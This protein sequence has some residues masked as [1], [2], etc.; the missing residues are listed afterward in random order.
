MTA[1]KKTAP[2]AAPKKPRRWRRRILL[3]GLLPLVA[4]MALFKW[5]IAPVLIRQAVMVAVAARI[6][7]RVEVRGASLGF[8]EVELKGVSLLDATGRVA[9]TADAVVIRLDRM[10]FG[11]GTPGI[12]SLRLV[13]PDVSMT[14]EAD[15]QIDLQRVLSP[16]PPA[17]PAQVL[18]APGGGPPAEPAPPPPPSPLL[19]GKISV[20]GGTLRLVTSV[21]SPT[22]TGLDATIDVEPRRFV[23]QTAA[24]GA[25]GGRASLSG[26]LGRGG[27]AGWALQ[28]NVA[29]ADVRELKKGTK[30]ER[31]RLDGRLDGFLSLER[32]TAG[33]ALGAGWLDIRDGH[34]L[35]LPVLL[36]VLNLLRLNAPGDSFVHSWRTDFQVLADRLH[37][38]RSYVMTDGICLFGDGDIHFEGQRVDLDFVPRLSG[39]PPEGYETLAE[40][41]EPVADFVRRNL[42]A[43]IEVKGTWMSPVA[44]TTPLRV[45]TGPLKDFFG[46]LKGKGGR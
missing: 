30:L 46:L 45:I 19:P 22:F 25:L 42:L 36:S 40:A 20:E 35:E 28:A 10:P 1:T 34:L 15:G 41:E 7:G 13:R 32:G 12:E 43:N 8:R 9:G 17:I 18:P 27:E 16:P 21:F 24:A 39:E 44:E 38:E 3:F 23:L 4:F 6:R 14:V 11:F 29:A 5:A 2:A 37:V 31:R 33:A 26:W